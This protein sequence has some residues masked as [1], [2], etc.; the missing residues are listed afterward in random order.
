MVHLLGGIKNR[1]A[2]KEGARQGSELGFA[3][4]DYFVLE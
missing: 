3:P 1:V 4:L 2:M